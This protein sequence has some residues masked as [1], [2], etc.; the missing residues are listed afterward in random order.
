MVVSVGIIAVGVGLIPTLLFYSTP[1]DQADL[2]IVLAG[3]A[4]PRT[5]YAIFLYDAG[6]SKKMLMTGGKVYDTTH[7]MLMKTYAINRGV[8]AGDIFVETASTSTYENAQFSLRIAEKQKVSSIIVVTSGYHS[9]RSYRIFRSVFPEHI[10]VYM[11]PSDG[12]DTVAWLWWTDP[13]LLESRGIEFFKL[14][15]YYLYYL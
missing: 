9:Y 3:D 5:D 12:S 10:Q 14:I 13:S 7:A 8:S 11:M 1:V 15:F 6:V 2:M 4:G